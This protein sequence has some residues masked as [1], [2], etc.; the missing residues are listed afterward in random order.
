MAARPLPEL[1]ENQLK[2]MLRLEPFDELPSNVTDLYWEA[3]R[4]ARRVGMAI[5]HHELIAIILLLDCAPPPHPQSFLDVV[6]REEPEYGARLVVEWKGSHHFAKYISTHR[7]DKKIC[8]EVD[9]D[10]ADNRMIHPTKVR[11][12]SRE[13]LQAVGEGR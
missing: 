11:L 3:E 10:S 9:G 7:A 12:A 6:E 4:C 8:V 2:S 13:E 1:H 5:T